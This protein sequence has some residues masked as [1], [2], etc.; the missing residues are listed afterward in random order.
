MTSALAKL[1]G[2]RIKRPAV[3]VETDATAGQELRVE[4]L[5]RAALEHD[6][7]IGVEVKSARAVRD[8][9]P[10]GASDAQVH[11]GSATARDAFVGADAHGD[12]APPSAFNNE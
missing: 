7:A 3:G 11:H 12:A 9:I 5:E 2:D 10:I 1:A 4:R 8:R 6:P